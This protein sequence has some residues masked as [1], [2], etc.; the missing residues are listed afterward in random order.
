MRDHSKKG[1]FFKIPTEHCAHIVLVD[2]SKLLVVVLLSM[3]IPDYVSY[4][5]YTYRVI[6][7]KRSK[8]ITSIAT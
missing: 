3:L 7:K 8:L 1:F 5:I 4:I 6:N 2:V